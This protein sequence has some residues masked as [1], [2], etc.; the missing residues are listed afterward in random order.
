MREFEFPAV[1]RY[2]RERGRLSAPRETYFAASS[3]N[4]S[5]VMKVNLTRALLL[6]GFLLFTSTA[7]ADDV[8][9]GRLLYVH[10]CASCH[11]VKGDGRGPVAPELKTAPTDLR[12]LS[13]RYGNPLPEDRIASFIDGRADIVAHGPREMPIWGE[14]VWKYPEGQGPREQVTSRIADLVA[15][16]QSIQETKQHASLR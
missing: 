10:H 16:L 1:R 2:L 3:R 5:D 7:A 12:F 4:E 11:G 14:E 6:S 8:A 9:R 13:L 15:Y